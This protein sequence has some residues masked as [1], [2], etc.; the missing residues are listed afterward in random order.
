MKICIPVS[1]IDD[2]AEGRAGNV[3]LLGRLL[4]VEPVEVR[5]PHGLELVEGHNDFLQLN[6]GNPGGLE[7]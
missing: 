3:H 5:E 4:L 2:A 6:L 7:Y 1:R